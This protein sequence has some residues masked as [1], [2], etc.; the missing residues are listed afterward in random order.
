MIKIFKI[1]WQNVLNGDAK[2]LIKNK[3]EK[4]L[5]GKMHTILTKT[6]WFTKKDFIICSKIYRRH[7]KT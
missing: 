5:N 7:K 6:I 3:N 1:K 4:R 2:S